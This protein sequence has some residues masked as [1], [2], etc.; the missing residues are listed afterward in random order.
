MLKSNL[1]GYSDSYIIIKVAIYLLA[2]AANEDDKAK[3]KMLRLK[4]MLHLDHAFQ[5]LP[6]H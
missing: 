6:V 3:K 1:Y 4:I 2:T 5:K